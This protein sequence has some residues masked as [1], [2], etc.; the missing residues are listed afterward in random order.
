MT[1]P[2]LFAEFTARTALERLPADKRS[3]SLN[4]MMTEVEQ[5]AS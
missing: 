4:L 2:R 5:V 1:D 3:L